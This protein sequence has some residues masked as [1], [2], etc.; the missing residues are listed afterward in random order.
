MCASNKYHELAHIIYSKSLEKCVL[1]RKLDS[2][3]IYL[4]HAGTVKQNKTLMHHIYTTDKI[5]AVEKIVLC[6]P[7]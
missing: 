1:R 3:S 4:V 5:I 7:L 6:V 2:L